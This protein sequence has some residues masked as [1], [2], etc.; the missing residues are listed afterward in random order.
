MNIFLAGMASG[1]SDIFAAFLGTSRPFASYSPFSARATHHAHPIKKVITDAHVDPDRRHYG[2]VR[3]RRGRKDAKPSLVPSDSESRKQWKDILKWKR[4]NWVTGP[5][6]GF[7]MLNELPRDVRDLIFKYVGTSVPCPACKRYK[8]CPRVDWYTSRRTCQARTYT[9]QNHDRSRHPATVADVFKYHRS[10]S[11]WAPKR[12]KNG[13][14][15]T[16]HIRTASRYV[17]Y[18]QWD[19]AYM[20]ACSVYDETLVVTTGWSCPQ[21]PLALPLGH[22]RPSQPVLS[23]ANPFYLLLDYSPTIATCSWSI[24]KVC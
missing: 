10:V 15:Y 21:G 11:K 12:L 8:N 20:I 6:V 4:G 22:V 2:N 14:V 13:A 19:P 24:C 16:T 5:G 3:Q 17:Y 1:H 23:K 9:H 18:N 7:D